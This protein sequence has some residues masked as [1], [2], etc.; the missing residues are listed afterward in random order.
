MI[1]CGWE[2]KSTHCKPASS[3]SSLFKPSE[4]DSQ[5]F[6]PPYGK[7]HFPFFS[8]NKRYF[9]P[10]SSATKALI[11]TLKKDS[12]TTKFISYKIREIKITA[13]LYKK[14]KKANS[15]WSLSM[16]HISYKGNVTTEQLGKHFYQ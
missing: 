2:A 3:A 13:N 9:V 11:L 8:W 4:M 1:T 16:M 7:S 14:E 15:L 6:N 5:K 12:G 10:L